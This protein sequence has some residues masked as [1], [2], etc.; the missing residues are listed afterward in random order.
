MAIR[1]L[2]AGLASQGV[3]AT[4]S[5]PDG[6]RYGSIDLD[7]N[8][9]DVRIAL[10]GP[11]QNPFTAEVLAA[12]GPAAGQALAAQLAAGGGARLWV[13]AA[14]SREQAFRPGADVRGVLDLPVLIVAGDDLADAAA[15]VTADLA[16]AVVEAAALGRR[17]RR[18][19]A[20]R[21]RPGRPLGGAAQPRH[22]EQPGD[23]GRHAVHLADAV[24][25]RLALRGLDRR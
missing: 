9:P 6:P 21:A 13:P 12:A 15:A 23:A 19:R 4:C 18:G 14:V 10:G 1:A 25:Q 7:S 11:E 24:L 8:L 16:D 17:G 5:R 2:L 20:G 3:T 22:A